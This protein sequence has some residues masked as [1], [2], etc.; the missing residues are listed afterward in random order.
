[1]PPVLDAWESR[2]RLGKDADGAGS[3]AMGV[4]T[5]GGGR[6]GELVKLP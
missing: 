3:V 5:P 4:T 2:L 1:V 6:W